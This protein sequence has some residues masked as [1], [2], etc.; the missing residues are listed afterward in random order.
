MAYVIPSKRNKPE[1]VPLPN[2]IINPSAR[3]GCKWCHSIDHLSFTCKYKGTVLDKRPDL[4]SYESF[5]SLGE[6]T[7]NRNENMWASK[8]LLDGIK[9]W[10]SPINSNILPKVS[11]SKLSLDTLTS[12]TTEYDT[13]DI[14]DFVRSTMSYL[15]VPHPFKYHYKNNMNILDQFNTISFRKWWNIYL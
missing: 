7:P 14:D 10:N 8:D 12:D 15:E 6:E 9:E 5:P 1:P 4:S 11:S 13:H 3:E 2:S